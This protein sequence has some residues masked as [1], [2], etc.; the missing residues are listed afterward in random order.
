VFI[1]LFVIIISLDG[2]GDI[3]RCLIGGEY[4]YRDTT[5]FGGS[6]LGH[7]KLVVSI[8]SPKIW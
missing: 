4:R 5:K 1:G 6:M 7:N 3:H 2:V 8:G